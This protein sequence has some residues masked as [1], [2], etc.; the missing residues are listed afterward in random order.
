MCVWVWAGLCDCKYPQ[1][2]EA[3]DPLEVLSQAVGSSPTVL[4]VQLWSSARA[5]HSLTAEL[6][7]QPPP[8]SQ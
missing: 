2:S 8:T 7:L 6:S 1:R 5:A 4:E 3:L